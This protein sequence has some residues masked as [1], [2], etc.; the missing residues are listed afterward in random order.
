MIKKII[1]LL[2][3]VD[4]PA[5]PPLPTNPLLVEPICDS[6]GISY[7]KLAAK[8]TGFD[9]NF[10]I[11]EGVTNG[12]DTTTL[13]ALT[14]SL[15]CF[16]VTTLFDPYTNYR[17]RERSNHNIAILASA[18]RTATTNGALTDNLSERGVYFVTN[19]TAGA[20]Y[21][22]QPE[23]QIQDVT[24]GNYISVATGVALTASGTY[25]F[26][27]YPGITEIAGFAY[28]MALPRYWRFRMVHGNANSVTYSVSGQ[29]LK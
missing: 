13:G 22:I 11:V 10:G 16:S 20:G 29:V 24:S 14:T 12:N 3:A 4:D 15:V 18:A 1:Q 9:P 5:T 2:R 17:I 19:I 25:L 28:S 21:S 23:L 7:S 27:V 8:K 6:N 26:K